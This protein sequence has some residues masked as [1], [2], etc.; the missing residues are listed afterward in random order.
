MKRSWDA[1]FTLSPPST[2][3]G[4][5]RGLAP[6]RRIRP[7]AACF[8]DI[9]THLGDQALV[10]FG[11]PTAVSAEV[12]R[13][14]DG[15]GNSSNDSFTVRL[16]YPGFTVALS[17]NV[18]SALVRPRYHVRGTKGNYWKW[19]LDLQE[20]ALNKVTR[21]GDGPGDRNHPPTGAL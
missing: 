5:C 12:T 2:A 9:G 11:K 3:G 16:R 14:R 21:I 8:C 1:S 18:L 7:R 4:R 20:A 10:L 19:G 13:E 17:A 15:D 6:G